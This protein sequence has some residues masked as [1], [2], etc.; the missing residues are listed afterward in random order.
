MLL[1]LAVA[2]GLL[3]Y[4]AYLRTCDRLDQEGADQ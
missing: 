3:G 1:S 2:G 4:A